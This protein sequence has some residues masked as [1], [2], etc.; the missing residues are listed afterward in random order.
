MAA[1]VAASVRY[2][3]V[4][5]FATFLEKRLCPAEVLLEALKDG[6]GVQVRPRGHRRARPRTSSSSRH[7]ELGGPPGSTRRGSHLTD[8]AHPPRPPRWRAQRPRRPPSPAPA[9]RR[10]LAFFCDSSRFFAIPRVFL[11]FLAFFCDSSR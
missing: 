10:F 2:Q 6:G 4:L 1:Q 8:A 11:R 9:A 3:A 7:R 5:A